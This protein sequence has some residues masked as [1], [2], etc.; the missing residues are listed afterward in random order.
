M[1]QISLN[2]PKTIA[3][4]YPWKAKGAILKHCY[5]GEVMII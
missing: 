2:L 5:E 1:S 3:E 4:N